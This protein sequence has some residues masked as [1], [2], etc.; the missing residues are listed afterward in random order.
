MAIFAFFTLKKPSSFDTQKIFDGL[1][2]SAHLQPSEVKTSCFNLGQSEF[3]ALSLST[4]TPF[5]SEQEQFHSG[6]RIVA[7][8]G[9]AYEYTSS[10]DP[11]LVTANC[12][13]RADQI[14]TAS[15]IAGEYAIVRCDP[16]AAEMLAYS[17]PER[18]QNLFYINTPEVFGVSTRPGL[19]SALSRSRNINPTS[20]AWTSAL[21][22]SFGDRTGYLDV[23]SVPQGKVLIWRNKKISFEA[24]ESPL[25]QFSN[26]GLRNNQHEVNEKIE[27]CLHACQNAV[28]I[29]AHGQ[30]KIALPITG[31][32]DSRLILALCLAANLKDRLE[33][34]TWGSEEHPDVIVSKQ[35]S[36]LTGLRHRVIHTSGNKMPSMGADEYLERVSTMAFQGDS[37]LGSW[38]LFLGYKC[39]SEIRIGGNMGEILKSFTKRPFEFKENRPLDL[40]TTGA[41]FDKMNVVKPSI[42]KSMELELAEQLFPYLENGFEISDLP[43]LFYYKN[44]I[45]N[46]LGNSRQAQ[47]FSL[48]TVMPMSA[49][50]LLQLAFQ[51]T[52]HERKMEAIHYQIIN[53]LSPSLLD[54]PFAMQSW[55]SELGH[56]TIKPVSLP[57]RPDVHAHGSWQYLINDNDE[58]RNRIRNLVSEGNSVLWTTLDQ[59]KVI[60]KLSGP[61]LSMGEIVSILAILP[62]LLFEPAFPK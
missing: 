34:F 60:S 5:Y 61:N 13:A 50:P 51:A 43:D 41:P 8:N 17:D 35:I 54:I 52:A 59:D 39:S 56:K 3:F 58:I 14:P 57:Q 16:S 25:K 44:R 30:D 31:G 2:R 9:Y 46:W 40:I 6:K 19:L 18:I 28:K 12:I 1:T 42:L 23:Q 48:P 45:P 24:I 38:D 22:Y 36:E 20:L 26:R 15:L 55:H 4:R 62:M 21:G 37:L 53:L 11:K 7:L 47:T 32:K 29:A 33:L 49:P 10:S 27:A